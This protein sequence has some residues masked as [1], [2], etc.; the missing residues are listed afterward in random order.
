[1]PGMPGDWSQNLWV[2]DFELPSS[3]QLTL[4]LQLGESPARGCIWW[5]SLMPLQILFCN[6]DNL[7]FRILQRAT[8]NE[9]L[10][11]SMGLSWV[12]PKVTERHSGVTHSSERSGFPSKRPQKEGTNLMVY[13]DS[14]ALWPGDHRNWDSSKRMWRKYE[15]PGDRGSCREYL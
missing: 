10:Q 15:V 9:N 11:Y 14:G 6:L 1:M 4:F 13:G 12:L 8:E 3:R 7:F 2:G 5:K